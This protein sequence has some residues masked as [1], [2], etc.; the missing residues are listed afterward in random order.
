M[1]GIFVFLGQGWNTH[2]ARIKPGGRGQISDRFP[3]GFDARRDASTAASGIDRPCASS[4]RDIP[5]RRK[6][7]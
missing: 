6:M 1:N 7:D 4:A 5:D 3:F 2:S